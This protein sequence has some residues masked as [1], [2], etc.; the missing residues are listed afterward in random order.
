MPSRLILTVFELNDG[1][2]DEDAT[3]SR[4]PINS[5]QFP[6][7]RSTV[8]T[9]S[10]S[11]G[12]ISI[13]RTVDGNSVQ[14]HAAAARN[15]YFRRAVVVIKITDPNSTYSQTMEMLDGAFVNYQFQSAP[16]G[17]NP[18]ETI[19]LGFAKWN[20]NTVSMDT[21]PSDSGSPVSDGWGEQ[22]L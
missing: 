4:I 13:S 14:L 11:S 8:D 22:I 1:K 5:V 16:S 18:N 3:F 21:S 7:Q 10:P 6:P 17:R 19:I 12:T 20:L 15:D 2:A 9:T